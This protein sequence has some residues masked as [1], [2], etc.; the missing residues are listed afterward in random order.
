MWLQ[1]IYST[2][3]VT[4]SFKKDFS[5]E[6]FPMSV[7][8]M[9]MQQRRVLTQVQFGQTHHLAIVGN[10]ANWLPVPQGN[11]KSQQYCQIRNYCWAQHYGLTD[12]MT[13]LYAWAWIPR[14][15][16][17]CPHIYIFKVMLCSKSLQPKTSLKWKKLE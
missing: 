11:L 4:F 2:I 6:L 13:C 9:R 14:I 12:I 10:A 1:E 5:P 15:I 3:V 8:I 17:W 7:Y 16:V